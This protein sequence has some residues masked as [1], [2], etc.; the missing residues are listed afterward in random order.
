MS[1]GPS[2]ILCMTTTAFFSI[3]FG[4]YGVIASKLRNEKLRKQKND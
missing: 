1:T 3:I 2:I 4:P